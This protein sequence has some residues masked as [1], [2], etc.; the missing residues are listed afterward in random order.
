MTSQTIN[1]GIYTSINVTASATLKM[2]P[3]VYVIAGGGFAVNGA[4]SV[5]GTGV[6]IYNAGS[7]YNGGPGST[8]GGITIDGSGKVT[9]SAPTTGAYAGS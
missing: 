4:A 7:N 2:N 3:G 5:T 9:L 1:P 8:F 6:T